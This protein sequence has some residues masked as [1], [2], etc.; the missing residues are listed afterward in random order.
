MIQVCKWIFRFTDSISYRA[1][2]SNGGVCMGQVTWKYAVIEK[3][4]EIVIA[5]QIEV[6]GRLQIE[7]M[8]E[9]LVLNKCSFFKLWCTNHSLVGFCYQSSLKLIKLSSIL[10]CLLIIV[11]KFASHVI[12]ICYHDNDSE[13]SIILWDCICETKAS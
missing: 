10:K 12:G 7:L 6:F 3:S 11:W 4:P 2:G 1:V 9:T 5:L 13:F 8:F